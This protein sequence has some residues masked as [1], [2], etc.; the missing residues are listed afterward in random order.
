[1]QSLNNTKGKS[2]DMS[3]SA[4]ER[5]ADK[6]LTM[7]YLKKSV[8]EPKEAEQK[9]VYVKNKT[10]DND[11]T[12]SA[13]STMSDQTENF[14]DSDSLQVINDSLNS[15]NYSA[16]NDDNIQVRKDKLIA[17]RTFEIIAS[18]VSINE[19]TAEA[20]CNAVQPVAVKPAASIPQALPT[21]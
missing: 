18:V 11:S 17:T 1:M 4:V 6:V 19:T 12:N 9:I 5:I 14:S 7:F 16:V 10:K 15:D 21:P 2:G 13:D 8:E 20:F 3:E